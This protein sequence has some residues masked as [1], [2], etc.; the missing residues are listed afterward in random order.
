VLLEA[1]GFIAR[2]DPRLAAFAKTGAGAQPVGG[3]ANP[4]KAGDA[5]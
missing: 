5:T 2:D 4:A 3:F 1:E